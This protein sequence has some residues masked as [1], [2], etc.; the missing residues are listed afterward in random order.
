MRRPDGRAREEYARSAAGG[1]DKMLT[2]VCA[3]LA[4]AVLIALLGIADTLTLA[5]HERVRERVLSRAVGRT[6][7]RLRAT[8]RWESVLVAAFGAAGGL[9]LG[10]FPGRVLV[11]ASDG[12][13]VFALPS[14]RL[15]VVAAVA[16]VGPAA[17][18]S[19]GPRP[20]RGAARMDVLRAIATE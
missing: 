6:R 19:A 2:L 16:A 9:V 8:V 18:A 17:G 3:L 11:R 1:T 14:A 12:A 15:A 5:I 20:A 10:G 4:L 13:F 7:A